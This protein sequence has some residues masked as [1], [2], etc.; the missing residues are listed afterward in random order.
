MFMKIKKTQKNTCLLTGLCLL[1]S[2]LCMA[3]YTHTPAKSK[4]IPVAEK[5][6]SMPKNYLQPID[7][8]ENKNPRHR[9]LAVEGIKQNISLIEKPRELRL[10]SHAHEAWLNQYRE[11]RQGITSHANNNSS[12]QRHSVSRR[13][14]APPESINA[15]SDDT[16]V[17]ANSS[18]AFA[19][20]TTQTLPHGTQ[21]LELPAASTATLFAYLKEQFTGNAVMMISLNGGC[22]ACI[23]DIENTHKL[24]QQLLAYPIEFILL[25]NK[26]EKEKW[27]KIL[28]NQPIKSVII[29][30]TPKQSDEIASLSHSPSRRVAMLIDI[31]GNILRYKLP[32]SLDRL[33]A[34]TLLNISGIS[35]VL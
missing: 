8:H 16:Q 18:A 24:Q 27:E 3:A 22:K 6:Q 9:Y 20:S 14:I 28:E 13:L 34:G 29:S 15:H 19:A 4:N 2:I 25:A 26:A 31:N 7:A 32:D 12:D 35:T 21:W 10:T 23:D 5:T 30:L 11:Y 1:L 17:L 33:T